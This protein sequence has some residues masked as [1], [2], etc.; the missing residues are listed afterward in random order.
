[1]LRTWFV[2][3]RGH[4]VDR[5]GE[6]LPRTGDAGHERLSAELS[7]VTDVARDA[8]DFRCEPVELV[9]HRVDGVLQLEDLAAH[10]DGDLLRK[11]ALGDGG[12]DFGDVTH[13]RGQVTGHEVHRV[14]EILPRTGDAA[15][16]GLSAELAF[17]TDFARDARHLAGEG[18]ELVDH[19]V[20]RRLQLENFAARVDRDLAREV[21]VRDGGR[22]FGDVTDLVRQVTGH[23]VDRVGQVFPRTADA[24]DLR[25]TAELAFG[26][27]LARDARDL[28]REAVELVDHRVDRVFEFEDFAADRNR[29]LLREVAVGDGRRDVGDV[30]H[31][32]GQVTGH[33]VHRVGEVLPRTGD[34]RDL[35]LSAE[36]AFGTDLARD[37]RDFRCE[38]V[39]LV[40][41]RVD[42]V[43]QLED[44]AA[45]VD[46]DLLRE[47]A[48]RDGGRDF[49]DV[50]DLRGQ[51]TGHQVDRL[52]Q[53]A[54]RSGD[55]F[56]AR[57]AAE[58]PFGTDLARDARHLA[59]E[60]VEL[61]DHR[62]DR[63]LEFENFA[64]RVDRDL[65]REVAVG[66]GGRH[67][68]DVANLRREVTGH[69][70]DRVGEVFPRTGDA[71]DL[72]LTA[73]LAFGTD[74]AR[75]A[76]HLAGEAR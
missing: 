50:T 41:H 40:D 56:D 27:D 32:R 72:G 51:V 9:D 5:V 45:H 1:M 38:P 42:R 76:R 44:L 28:E 31:L 10:V 69:A 19:R 57:L 18:V 20:D 39:E 71:A 60:R 54:P 24:F 4:R 33:E 13:L 23:R 55:A 63:A 67:V 14:G 48:L 15:D 17:G 11:V 22:D 58:L 36:L 49:G 73:E 26:T 46:D 70:V 59:G 74:F 25:L 61:V 12:R 3:L 68:G 2:R 8:R 53:V 35:G 7:F 65:A 62:V 52:G 37:A 16:L 47:V 21:A 43:L 6:I 64:A 30:A 75:D 66:D 34:A 29:D